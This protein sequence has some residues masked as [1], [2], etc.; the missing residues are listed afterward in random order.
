MAMPLPIEIR[1]SLLEALLPYRAAHRN[2]RWLSPDSWHLTLLFLGD[3]PAGEAP[4]LA[5]L[6]DAIA[7]ER[8]PIEIAIEGGDGRLQG[9]G[10]VAWLKVGKGAGSL[11]AVAD[12]LQR[13]IASEID[14]I[15]AARR[16]VSAHLTV[17]RK[18]DAGVISALRERRRGP[19]EAGWLA[20]RISLMRSHLE[21]G[22]SRYETLHEARCTL[23]GTTSKA[24]LEIRR[25]IDGEEVEDP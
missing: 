14:G 6:V 11:L 1:A 22:G 18:A 9:R 7:A 12:E 16:P 17:A 10:H 15:P 13:R 2:V 3:V 24:R 8:R 4:A 19:I 21:S 20:D 5:S 23:T 25:P